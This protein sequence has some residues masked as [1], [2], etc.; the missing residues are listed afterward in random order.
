MNVPDGTGF[1][2]IAYD[3]REYTTDRKGNPYLTYQEMQSVLSKSLLLYQNSHNGRMPKKIYVH[4]TTHFTEDEIQGAF[5]ALGSM[6]EIEQ[7]Q[8]VRRANW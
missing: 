8:I 4:K 5:D 7:V 2:F 3:T 1:E 6:M